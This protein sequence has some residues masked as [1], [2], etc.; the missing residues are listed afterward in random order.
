[1][2]TILCFGDSNTWGWD[3]VK[4]GRYARDVR[5][6]GVLRAALGDD[7]LVIEEG[8]NGRTTVWD[9]P[10]EGY[11]NGKEYLIP[12]LETHKPLDLVIVMLGTND[13]KMRFSVSAFDIAESAG[14]LI[15]I[16]QRSQTGPGDSAPKAL[17]I[18]PPPILEVGDFA[19]MFAGGAA[20]SLQFAPQYRRVAEFFGC[21]LLDAGRVIPSSQVDGIHLDADAH[22]KLGAAVAEKVKALLR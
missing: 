10:I 14:V 5:W 15:D 16:I 8:L 9:D 21:A 7:F 3:P 11:N 2:K 6:P 17:L 20:K 19:H 18:A 1:M 22:R 12:C 13:L 4:L